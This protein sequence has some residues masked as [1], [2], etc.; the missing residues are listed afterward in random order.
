MVLVNPKFNTNQEDTSGPE[1][2][3]EANQA[4]DEV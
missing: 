2:H 3:E 4:A 1:E